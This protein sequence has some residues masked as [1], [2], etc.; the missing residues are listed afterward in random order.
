MF[1]WTSMATR[2]IKAMSLILHKKTQVLYTLVT[3][4]YLLV[5]YQPQFKLGKVNPGVAIKKC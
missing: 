2:I 3:Y 5:M 1:R 4:K